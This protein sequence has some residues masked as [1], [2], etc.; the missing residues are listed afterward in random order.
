MDKNVL[1]NPG[2]QRVRQLASISHFPSPHSLL[3]D[4]KN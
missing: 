1:S 2:Q 4:N 3:R